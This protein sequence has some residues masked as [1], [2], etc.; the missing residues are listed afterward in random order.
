MIELKFEMLA[1][2]HFDYLYLCTREEGKHEQHTWS[3]KVPY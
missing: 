1:S 3:K 2:N